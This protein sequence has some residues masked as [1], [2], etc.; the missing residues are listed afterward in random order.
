MDLPVFS[1]GL[2][3]IVPPDGP[4]TSQPPA[5]LWHHFRA[6][7]PKRGHAAAGELPELLPAYLPVVAQRDHAAIDFSWGGVAGASNDA[8]VTFDVLRH[9]LVRPRAASATLPDIVAAAVSEAPFVVR[10]VQVLTYNLPGLPRPQLVLHRREDDPRSSPLPWDFRS[11]GGRVRTVLHFPSE[12]FADSAAAV[13]AVCPEMPDLHASLLAQRLVAI[14]ATG[15]IDNYLPDD[16]EEVQFITVEHSVREWFAAATGVPTGWPA[17][18]PQAP[19]STSTTTQI[20]GDNRRFRFVVL[21]GTARAQVEV[22]APCLQADAILE[23][24][25]MD[26][27]AAN[28][29]LRGDIHVMLARAHPP[30]SQG[31]QE[32]VFLVCGDFDDEHSTVVVDQTECGFPPQTIVLA[33]FTRCEIEV[34][35]P[36]RSQGVHLFANAVPVHLAQ[37]P[38]GQGD[39]FRFSAELDHPVATTASAILSALPVLDPFA[40]PIVAG[41]RP[42][43][44]ELP[45]Q[46]RLRRRQQ[47]AWRHQEGLV[48]VIGPDHGPLR[49]RTFDAVVPDLPDAL[50]GLARLTRHPARGLTIAV[51]RAIEPCRAIFATGSAHSCLQTVLLPA[52]GQRNHYL[53]LTVSAQAQ[54]FGKLPL[55]ANCIVRHPG[56]PW[57]TGDVVEVL[58]LANCAVP[59]IPQIVANAPIPRRPREAFGRLRLDMNTSAINTGRWSREEMTEQDRARLDALLQDAAANRFDPPDPEG[60]NPSLP[61]AN[62]RPATIRAA[63]SRSGSAPVSMDTATSEQTA[64]APMSDQP[65]APWTG[66]PLG[67]LHM[68]SRQLARTRSVTHLRLL[69]RERALFSSPYLFTNASS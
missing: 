25:L 41:D 17:W 14:D 8:F 31:V 29:P 67:P 13:Q 39:F 57:R 54:S 28:M 5:L 34:P 46:A 22:N 44:L 47:G 18:I 21:H 20:Q 36:W 69:L 43:Q 38:A 3:T 35:E 66:L 60:A 2:A 6:L 52:F 48:E 53:V 50:A 63:P 12:A 27:F 42:F 11:V 30:P 32:V 64:A 4:D 61:Q 37:R 62:R 58:D 24:L 40:W 26:V 7:D 1:D 59:F 33:P 56:R 9:A 23:S 19:T 65:P 10:A 15:L 45:R 55:P 51:T 68:L 16:L 49:F